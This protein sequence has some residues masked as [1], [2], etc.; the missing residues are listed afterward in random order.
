V[1]RELFGAPPVILRYVPTGCLLTV[2]G[3]RMT[4]AF[5]RASNGAG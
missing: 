5:E 4:I 2:V 1:L 3:F